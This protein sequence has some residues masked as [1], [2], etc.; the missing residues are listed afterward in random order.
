MRGFICLLLR[1]K[2]FAERY[3]IS[4][5]EKD[6]ER[7]E[8]DAWREEAGNSLALVSVHYS[9]R[10]RQHVRDVPRY[11][12][13]FSLFTSIGGSMSVY[14]GI[15]GVAYVELVEYA[16]DATFGYLINYAST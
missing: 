5:P 2:Y 7:K 11:A 16:W 10:R 8:V 9:S 3:N 4:A 14:M 1:R 12:D 13:V 15:S 6:P